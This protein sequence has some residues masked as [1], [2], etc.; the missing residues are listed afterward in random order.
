MTSPPPPDLPA[1]SSSGASSG[2]SGAAKGPATDQP[3]TPEA[4]PPAR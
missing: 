3:Q 2:S 1:G 4:Q